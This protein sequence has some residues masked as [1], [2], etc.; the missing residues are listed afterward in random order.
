MNSLSTGFELSYERQK[1][2]TPVTVAGVASLYDPNPADVLTMPVYRGTQ[3]I[4]S[5]ITG[6]AYAFETLNLTRDFLLNGGVRFDG[7]H[8]D[9]SSATYTAAAGSTPA[10]LANNAPIGLTGQLWSYK[11]G[12][13]YKPAHNGSVY[14][15]Y[16]DSKQP[17]GGTNFALSGQANSQAQAGLKP[18]EGTNI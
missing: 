3:T 18:Q 13:V 8:T 6:S 4:G 11:V 7:F 1:T 5:T 10:T 9:T 15:T 17:P 14:A 16:S 2:A 12:A